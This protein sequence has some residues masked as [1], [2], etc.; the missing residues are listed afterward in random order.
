V[1]DS[2]AHVPS[3]APGGLRL[4]LGGGLGV[5]PDAVARAEAALASLSS[6]FE[7]WMADE[8]AKLDAAWARVLAEG[9]NAQTL[10]GLYMRAHDLKGLGATY[11]YPL[12]TRIAG[13]LCRLLHDPAR[14]LAAPMDLLQAHFGAIKH[15]VAQKIRTDEDPWAAQ[16]AADLE[17]R[18]SAALGE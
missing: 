11:Q 17:T 7:T 3:A 14:R 15:A 1:S 4:R 12:V 8:I 13:S 18:T 5:D 10:E 2:H 16:A 6:N 9:A